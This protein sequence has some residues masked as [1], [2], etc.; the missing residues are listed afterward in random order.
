MKLYLVLFF[1][2]FLTSL[3]Y[4]HDSNRTIDF[5][6]IDGRKTLVCDFHQ[7]T[8]FSD[9][10]VWPSI[11]V[12]EATKDGLDAISITDHIE[13]QPHQKD[14]PH[15]DRNR[16]YQ[17]A[18]KSAEKTGLIVIR[19]SEITRKMPPGHVNAIFLKDSNALLTDDA[20]DALKIAHNQGAFL[21]WNHPN[22]L[23]QAK[24]GVAQLTDMHKQLIKDKILSGIEVVNEHS[25]S[26]EAIQIALDHNLAMIGNSDIHNLVD[27]DYDVPGGGHRPVTLVFAKQKTED[28][29]KEALFA[30]KTAVYFKNNLIGGEENLL[31]LI[32]ASLTIESA[33]YQGD[34]IVA[35]IKIVNSSDMNYLLQNT[36][37]YKLH[38]NTDMLEIKAHQTVILHVKTLKR[39]SEL[40][41]KFKVLNAISAP[42]SHP[43]I[44][45]TV[46]P[47]K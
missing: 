24:D 29:L 37:D 34:K 31:P 28:S 9:G 4:A 46:K 33:K 5:P 25:F 1:S 26:D 41:L 12:Q 32:R 44:T 42:N 14:L 19:G 8:V 39:L 10:L 7:H 35:Q 18:Q 45:F 38:Q 11:R 13:Y 43:E 3:A 15:E 22:W 47:A 40:H 16:S 6:D 21:F 30:G 27:W 36:G 2:C 20:Y 17:I 23:S